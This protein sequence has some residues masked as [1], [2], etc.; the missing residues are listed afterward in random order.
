[1]CRDGSFPRCPF[2]SRTIC[3]FRIRKCA[4]RFQHRHRKKEL[5]VFSLPG[6]SQEG[7]AR[8]A[9]P[10][11]PGSQRTETT[12]GTQR[13]KSSIGDQIGPRTRL[14]LHELET[15]KTR[16]PTEKFETQE[17]SRIQEQTKEKKKRKRIRRKKHL[18]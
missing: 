4:D 17:R 10:T 3:P 5:I 11:A 12:P 18:K 15:Q 13:R 9:C 14:R 16:K 2:G 7:N 6:L 8:W 1:M